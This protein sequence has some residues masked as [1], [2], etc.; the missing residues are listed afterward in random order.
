MHSISKLLTLFTL[1]FSIHVYANDI[2]EWMTSLEN[3]KNG[4]ECAIGYGRAQS[5]TL[6]QEALNTGLFEIG[7]SKK[8]KISFNIE[9]SSSVRTSIS[10]QIG[11]RINKNGKEITN[12]ISQNG[13]YFALVC[14]NSVKQNSKEIQGMLKYY[15]VDTILNNVTTSESVTSLTMRENPIYGNLYYKFIS[16]LKYLQSVKKNLHAIHPKNESCIKYGSVAPNWIYNPKTI[17]KKYI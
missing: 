14:S 8:I 10:K 2:P 7:F 15:K 11:S 12:W 9:S 3:Y 13:D 17:N 1:L 16:S 4:S 5:L 6:T